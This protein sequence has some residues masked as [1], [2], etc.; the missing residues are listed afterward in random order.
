LRGVP[1]NRDN[2]RRR[3]LQPA[4]KAANVKLAELGIEPI[5]KVAP[6]GLRRTYASLCCAAGDSPAYTAAQLG[7]VD[8]AFTM[9]VYTEATKHRERLSPVELKA[10]DEALE[11]AQIG[12]KLGRSS[13]KVLAR[14]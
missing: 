1:D 3:L 6:H 8:P 13:R 7:H 2:V 11:W 5:G 9:R 4:I 14:K 10:Y 12:A